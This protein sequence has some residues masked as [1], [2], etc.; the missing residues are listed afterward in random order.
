MSTCTIVDSMR[1]FSASMTQTHIKSWLCIV[2]VVCLALISPMV[3]TCSDA[4]THTAEPDR[5]PPAMAMKRKIN[6]VSVAVSQVPAK[7][8]RTTQHTRRAQ[9][10]AVI[11]V[12][13][14]PTALRHMEGLKNTSKRPCYPSF[15]WL[16]L[17][18]NCI[19]ALGP[20]AVAGG[21]CEFELHYP[22]ISFAH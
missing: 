21:F 4:L 22:V 10:L 8:S 19:P 6:K 13:V 12:H 7:V 3:S 2:L 16:E 11:G 5:A 17:S 14:M 20:R 15:R 9:A 1:K 18:N